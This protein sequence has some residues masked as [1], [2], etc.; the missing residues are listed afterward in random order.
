MGLGNIEPTRNDFGF[1]EAKQSISFWPIP[2]TVLGFFL[3]DDI[4]SIL[5]FY[6]LVGSCRVADLPL[7][8]RYYAPFLILH[9]LLS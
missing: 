1:G 8:F 7:S 3:T 2:L 6:K 9:Y 4:L 5:L